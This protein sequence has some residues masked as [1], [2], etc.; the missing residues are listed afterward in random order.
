MDRK[1]FDTTYSNGSQDQLSTVEDF[2]SF[3]R[4]LIIL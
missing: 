3:E 1:H 2:E 4:V